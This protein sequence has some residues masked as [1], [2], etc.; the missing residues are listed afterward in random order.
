MKVSL[1]NTFKKQLTTNRKK[2]LNSLFYKDHR[3]ELFSDFQ[4]KFW[5][6]DSKA[7]DIGATAFSLEYIEGPIIW[8]VGYSKI[9]RDLDFIS[10]LVFSKVDEII[11]YGAH[12]THI[13][14]HFGSIVK[15]SQVE[16][17][18]GAFKIALESQTNNST[19]LFSPA[20]TSFPIHENYKIRGDY[21]K[22]LIEQL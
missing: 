15:Y 3:L 20:C 13:K 9:K 1:K 5:I 22:S 2:A 19:I 10:D 4:G 7:T 14:Y 8:I 16:D 11:Y 21:F 6:N 18:K 17:I 12:E